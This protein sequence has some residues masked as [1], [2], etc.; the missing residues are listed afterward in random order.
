MLHEGV[1]VFIG[2]PLL[3]GGAY[4][5]QQLFDSAALFRGQCLFDTQQLLVEIK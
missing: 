5:T 4:S 2:R 1:V 3:E